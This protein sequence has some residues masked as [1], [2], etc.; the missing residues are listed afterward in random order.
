MIR[1]PPLYCQV[2]LTAVLLTT[3]CVTSTDAATDAATQADIEWLYT[4]RP[5]AVAVIIHGFNLNPRIMREMAGKLQEEGHDVLL[6][7][8]TGHRMSLPPAERQD[9]LGAM[10]GFGAWQD[11]VD[12]AMN[13]AAGRADE[14]A[15]PLH[16]VGFS[17]G[18]L[19]AVDHLNRHDSTPLDRMVLLAPAL[20]LHWTSWLLRPLGPLPD[21]LLPSVGPDR[22]KA[23]ESVPVSAYEALYEGVAQLNE[24]PR[25]E[26]FDIPTLVLISEQDELVSSEGLEDFIRD[27]TLDRWQFHRIDNRAGD[28]DVL[29]HV[30]VDRNSLGEKAWQEVSG[31]VLQ[32]LDAADG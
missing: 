22:Y 18:G 32:F 25:P 26:R 27:H 29:D 23:N 7:S 28:G 14:L 11:N 9:E 3:G 12:Q 15:L 10:A 30:I 13:E 5:E 1:T 6:L 2:L 20:S 17:M 19:L 24:Q 8:L 31:K 21:F 16:L 4:E